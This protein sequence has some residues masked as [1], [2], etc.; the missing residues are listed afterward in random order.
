MVMKTEVKIKRRD[1]LPLAVAEK[2]KYALDYNHYLQV[3]GLGF[4]AQWKYCSAKI[5][6]FTLK[7]FVYQIFCIFCRILRKKAKFLRKKINLREKVFR[8][9]FFLWKP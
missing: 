6:H 3:S 5:P 1:S 7:Y 8:K 9:V 2:I 4:S